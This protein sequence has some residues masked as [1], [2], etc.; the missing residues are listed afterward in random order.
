MSNVVRHKMVR[1]PIDCSLCNNRIVGVSRQHYSSLW[2]G[3]NNLGG[4]NKPT[5]KTI[6]LR[7]GQAV[8][9]TMH[10]SACYFFVFLD[11]GRVEDQAHSSLRHQVQQEK[12]GT[13]PAT[14]RGHNNVRV[15]DNP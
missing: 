12:R 9:P 3:V 4:G 14:E 5:Q 1:I 8:H 13:S 10:R 7:L 6:E 15:E 11:Q 2:R